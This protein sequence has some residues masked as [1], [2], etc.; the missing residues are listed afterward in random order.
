MLVSYEA[1]FMNLKWYFEVAFCSIEV[2]EF[3]QEP[4]KVEAVITTD[5]QFSFA[6]VMWSVRIEQGEKILRASSENKH[7]IEESQWKIKIPVEM[8]R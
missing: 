7:L 6:E 8:L 4:I 3:I 2:F 5:R 1:I